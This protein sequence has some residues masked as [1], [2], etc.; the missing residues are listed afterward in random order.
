MCDPGKLCAAGH[1]VHMIR[2]GWW[3]F[4]IGLVG[5]WQCFL[6]APGQGDDLLPWALWGGWLF[7]ICPRAGWW[8]FAMGLGTVSY[9]PQGRVMTFCHGPCGAGDSVFYM[10]QRPNQL[11][12]PNSWNQSFCFIFKWAIGLSNGLWRPECLTRALS[13]GCQ[14]SLRPSMERDFP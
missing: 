9:M 4:A 5:R 12:K 6:H 3:P 10:P 2:A 7:P 8:P 11:P 1:P 13:R 14:F